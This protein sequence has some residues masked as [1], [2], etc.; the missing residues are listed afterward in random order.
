MCQYAVDNLPVRIYN[1][2]V[3][4]I[5]SRKLIAFNKNNYM[6]YVVYMNKKFKHEQANKSLADRKSCV[7]SARD[8][9]LVITKKP[10]RNSLYT[11]CPEAF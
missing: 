5:L 8:F 1:L 11:P 2:F 3:K 9:C 6:L 7:L 4:Y 10:L